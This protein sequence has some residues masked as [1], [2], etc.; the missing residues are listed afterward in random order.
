MIN[1]QEWIN[2][3]ECWRQVT[4]RARPLDALVV[5]L[6]AAVLLAMMIRP[7]DRAVLG[8][9]LAVLLGLF[10]ARRALTASRYIEGVPGALGPERRTRPS[11]PRR[12][13]SLSLRATSLFGA[14]DAAQ[15]RRWQSGTRSQGKHAQSYRQ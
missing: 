13:A 10:A 11:P 7:E 6:I 9:P 8:Y 5:L 2:A 3:Q 1:A 15:I 14:A 4:E 12:S